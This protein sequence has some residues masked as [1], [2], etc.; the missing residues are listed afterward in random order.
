[1]TE[2]TPSGSIPRR[3]F[4][5]LGAGAALASAA[6]ADLHEVAGQPRKSG[7][8]T[9]IDPAIELEV[10]PAINADLK[11]HGSIFERKIYRV[12]E[13]VYSAIGWANGATVM[14]VGDNG[15]II[16]DTGPDIQSAREVAAEFR[17]IT[18]K[19]V[20]AIIYTAFHVDHISGVK[21]Y[22]SVEDV[23][24]GRVTIVAHEKLLGN[25]IRASETL[26]PILGIRTLYNFGSFL[27]KTFET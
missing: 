10:K 22:A 8:P 24:V 27:M 9:E 1:M 12:G 26:G 7:N 21:A 19:P 6:G 18:D 23:A 15:V 2:G 25:V 5:K 4:V 17:K 13:N 11:K 16:V 14:I 20:R 3:D